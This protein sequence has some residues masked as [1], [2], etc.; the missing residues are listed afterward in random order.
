MQALSWLSGNNAFKY[1]AVAIC[2]F[3]AALLILF[4]FRLAFGGRLRM[5]SGR[6]RQHRLGIVDAFDLDRQ[7][8]LVIVRRDNI[9]H[10]I[11]IGGPNDILIES[12]IVRAEARDL[13]ETRGRDKELK[14]PQMPPLKPPLPEPKLPL[15]PLMP[16]PLHPAAQDAAAPVR[17][18]PVS[19]M[20]A[21]PTLPPG[22]PPRRMP[23]R[24][25]IKPLPPEPPPKPEPEP[26]AAATAPNPPAA[27]PSPASLSP[28]FLRWPAGPAAARSPKP[29]AAAPLP[30]KPP[31]A[32]APSPP[33][34]AS[35]DSAAPSE[36]PVPDAMSL[37]EEMAKLLGRG[38]SKP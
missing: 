34:P 26:A 32:P 33:P 35:A 3:A 15:P 22:T 19:P 10:L 23:P 21:A 37:E 12:Q 20:P 13:R 9:E 17:L 29:S 36:P 6:G 14:E 16:E 1:A 28:S 38:P 27:K 18:Q 11:M 7:R 24:P 2:F 25:D 4:V 31:A 30:P 5:S 8:Q